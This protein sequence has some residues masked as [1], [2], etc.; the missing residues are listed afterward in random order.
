MHSPDSTQ[1]P[2]DA[3]DAKKG[4]I[5][6]IAGRDDATDTGDMTTHMNMGM[7]NGSCGHQPPS[8]MNSE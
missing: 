7:S 4:K 2:D 5:R 6:R 8:M 1:A 3:A